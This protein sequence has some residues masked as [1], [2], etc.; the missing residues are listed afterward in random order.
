MPSKCMGFRCLYMFPSTNNNSGISYSHCLTSDIF[1]PG[2]ILRIAEGDM[3]RRKAMQVR[4]CLHNSSLAQKKHLYQP[5][6]V[7]WGQQQSL[8]SPKNSINH[9]PSLIL[10]QDLKVCPDSQRVPGKQKWQRRRRGRR[11]RWRWCWCWC[12]WWWWRRRW[13]WR[14]RW[15][16][17]WRWRWCCCCCCWCWWWWWCLSSWNPIRNPNDCM[18][19][20]SMGPGDFDVFWKSYKNFLMCIWLI[21]YYDM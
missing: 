4:F 11:W 21:P 16:W 2:L 9:S 17:R 15:Q 3:P 7:E 18:V 5:L 10:R 6:S 1:W 20:S 8:G 13:R 14:W 12:W 19:N